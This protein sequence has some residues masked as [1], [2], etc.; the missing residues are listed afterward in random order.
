MSRPRRE[1]Y[2]LAG[3]AGPVSH[4]THAVRADDLLFLSGFLAVTEDG[5]LVGGDDVTERGAQASRRAWAA[6]SR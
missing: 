6:S 4:S 2:R 5:Q 3:Q 1:E